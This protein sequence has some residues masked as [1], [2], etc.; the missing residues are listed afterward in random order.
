MYSPVFLA[1]VCSRLAEVFRRRRFFNLP[2]R[3]ILISSRMF[4]QRIS[5]QAFGTEFGMLHW[6]A[7][8]CEAIWLTIITKAASPRAGVSRLATGRCFHSHFSAI[9]LMREKFSICSAS[10]FLATRDL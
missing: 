8:L 7:R 4:M 5:E 10:A 9:F 1:E 6:M 3:A 2:A